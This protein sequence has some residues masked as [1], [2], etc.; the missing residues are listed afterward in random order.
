MIPMTV[1]P[2]RGGFLRTAGISLSLGSLA[3]L[4][5]LTTGCSGGSGSAA[6][7]P[8]IRTITRFTTID[9]PGG[10]GTTINGISSNGAVVG[11]TTSNGVN[12]NFLR[13]VNGAFTAVN[14]GDPAAGMVNG[15]NSGGMLVGVANNS[16]FTLANGTQTKLTPPG[17]ASSIAFGLNESGAIVGQFVSGNTT[18]GFLDVNGTFTTIN[19]TP[20]AMVTN[21]QGINNKGQAIG[22]Y[23]TDGVHQHGFLYNIATQQVTLLP[24]PNTP[25]I[26]SGGLVLTQ[27]LGINDNNEAVGYYQT[28]NGS[29]FGFLFNLAT[30]TY[31]FLDAPQAAPVNSVQ[32]TQITGVTNTGEICGFFIDAQGVQ[33]GFIAQ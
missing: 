5:L 31:T 4:G 29:Q 32:I 16:A 2:S 19:P 25:R 1:H 7:S 20:N 6:V 8:T 21:V 22:F 12:A 13:S 18:P 24:D 33:H 17:S 11:F 15:V 27:F 26:V 23:S 28:N 10:G 9:G 3:L 30:Q 14:V